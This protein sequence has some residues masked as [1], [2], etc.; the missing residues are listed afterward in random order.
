MNESQYFLFVRASHT[1]S[2]ST[3]N[4]VTWRLRALSLKLSQHWHRIE[5]LGGRRKLD[6]ENL[7]SFCSNNQWERYWPFMFSAVSFEQ[8]EAVRLLIFFLPCWFSFLKKWYSTNK[9]KFSKTSRIL[10]SVLPSR[11]WYQ[12]SG[13]VCSMSQEEGKIEV[14]WF[15]LPE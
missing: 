11:H 2:T 6:P 14:L 7:S 15:D 1:P 3:W 10:E 12:G 5:G 4:R 13:W 9:R 8:T